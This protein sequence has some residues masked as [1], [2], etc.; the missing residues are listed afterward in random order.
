MK[1]ENGKITIKTGIR[2][3]TDWMDD[4][5]T[6]LYANFGILKEF[7]EKEMRVNKHVDWDSCPDT[8]KVKKEIEDLYAW[9]ENYDKISNPYWEMGGKLLQNHGFDV[10]DALAR[11]KSIP[12]D[13]LVKYEKLSAKGNKLDTKQEKEEDDNLLRLMKIRRWLW[14]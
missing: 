14:T 13:V 1:I 9:W 6:L 4:V 2:R 8:K 10:L 5:E 12:K 7:V 11:K 3:K